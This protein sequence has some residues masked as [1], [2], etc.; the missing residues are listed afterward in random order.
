LTI[1]RTLQQAG[2][3]AFFAGG[4]VRDLLL[5]RS[6][7]DIDV[8]TS[9]PPD[10]VERRFAHT[11]PV[12]RQFGV[13]VVVAGDVH[14]EVATFR[15]D[16]EYLDGRHPSSIRFASAREDALRRDFTVNALFLDPLTGE[17]VDF[18]GGRGDLQRRLI[19]TVG[20]ARERFKED[21]LRMLRAVR[22]ACQLDFEIEPACFEAVQ[23]LAAQI[24]EVS[25]ERIRDEVVKI[26][27]GP[28]PARGLDL[29]YSSGLLVEV[30]PE[31]AAMHGVPQ[32]PEYH[33]EGDVFVHTR[34]M[35]KLAERPD[36]ALALAI[37][38]HDIGKPPTLAVKDRIRFDGHADVGAE[39]AAA[40]CRRL[41]LSNEV[42][43]EAVDLVRQHL[44]FIPVE[45]MR[46]STLKRFLRQENF[47]KHLE[48][49]RLDCLA[50]HGQLAGYDYC[51]RKL[52]EFGR[53]AMRPAPLLN[54]RHLIDLGLAPGPVFA[55]I[56]DRLEDLQLEGAISD[57]SQA[58]E[59]VRRNYLSSGSGGR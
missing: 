9:A 11:V 33:P 4:V 10:E 18:V 29:L 24:L 2:F 8:A 51:R 45:Q 44:R 14:Y 20:S 59:W 43:N 22:F 48:L 28:D 12:G 53:E 41:K 31:V 40:V 17:V 5:G 56:L 3:Q 21:R 23:D 7:A 19:R 57:T 35:L 54:G 38:L 34:L 25:W 6:V 36:A 26:L 1:V 47:A 49:H 30:L 15:S 58:L 42:V 52:E 27:I 37:L 13:I 46:E 16:S 50:S 39:M 55:E 32:P